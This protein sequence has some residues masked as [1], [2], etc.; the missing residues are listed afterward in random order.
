CWLLSRVTVCSLLFLTYSGRS[1]GQVVTISGIINIYS[2]VVSIDYCA[3]SLTLSSMS[4]FAQGDEVLIIQMKG[5]RCDS[6]DSPTFG[7]IVDPGEAGNYELTFVRSIAGS[8]VVLRDGLLRRY[9]P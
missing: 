8:T 2:P 7:S 1:Q 4:G 3:N 5:V 6:S 9:D